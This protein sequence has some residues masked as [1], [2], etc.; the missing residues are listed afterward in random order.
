MIDY[1][2]MIDRLVKQQI[3]SGKNVTVTDIDAPFAGWAFPTFFTT[4][5]RHKIDQLV[6]DADSR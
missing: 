6:D 1:I 5:I 4:N 2:E 3:R